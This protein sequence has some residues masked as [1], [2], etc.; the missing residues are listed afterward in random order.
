MIRDSRASNKYETID[1]STVGSRRT[2]LYSPN[3]E[4]NFRNTLTA[5]STCIST[6]GIDDISKPSPTFERVAS[7]HLELETDDTYNHIDDGAKVDIKASICTEQMTS[8]RK[9]NI[10]RS[11]HNNGTLVSVQNDQENIY[12]C[13]TDDMSLSGNIKCRDSLSF[14]RQHGNYENVKLEEPA[15][16]IN[17]YFILEQ[18]DQYDHLDTVLPTGDACRTKGQSILDS[19]Y[20]EI[21]FTKSAAVADPN[22]G[23]LCQDISPEAVENDITYS[24]IGDSVVRASAAF[25]M[26]YSYS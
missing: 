9:D 20:N 7:P 12:V 13:Y 6:K 10:Q 17:P 23:V 19:E 11:K 16:E 1:I 26:D 5:G 21:R 25:T 2:R 4:D 24:H 18:Y 22:Y 3:S 15:S 14:N 8:D